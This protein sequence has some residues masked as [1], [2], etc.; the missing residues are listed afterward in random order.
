MGDIPSLS[1]FPSRHYGEHSMEGF[2]NAIRS[3]SRFINVIAGC[4]LTFMMLLTVSDVFLRSLRRPIV[5]TYELVALCGAIVIGFSLPY[6]SWLR[7]HIYVDFIV[8]KFPSK[9]RGAFHVVTRCLS[10]AFFFIVGWNLIKM[11]MDLTRTGEVSLTLQLP[12]YPVAYGEAFCCFLQ[13]LV[14]LSDIVKIFGGR[15]E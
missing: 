13:C 6:T 7:G 8:L 1:F 15:Y 3:F 14:L 11:G 5:G 10:M 2:L 4:S 12:F 9:I